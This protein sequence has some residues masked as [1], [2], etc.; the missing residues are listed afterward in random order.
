MRK[1]AL[2]A[3]LFVFVLA[4][5][6][7]RAVNERSR[8]SSDDG[9]EDGERSSVVRA[10]V[11]VTGIPG[12][13]AIAQVG[14]FHK[15]GPFIERPALAGAAH[16]VLDR[17]RLLVA[18]TSNFGA[19]PALSQPEG[20]V[21][22]IDVSG[23]LVAVPPYFATAGTQA[24]AFGDAVILY[25][26]QSAPYQNNV[27][28]GNAATRDLTAVSLP[29]GISL[30]NGFGRPWFAN[31]PNGSGG[32]GSIT[33]IDP[34]GFPLAGAPDPTAGG[35]FSGN[36]TNRSSATTHGIT[37]GAVATAL[38]TKS[39]DGGGKAVFLGALADG[40]VVQIHVQKG[41]DGLAP[42]GSF[43]AIPNISA[44]RAESADREV[45]TRAGMLFNWVPTRVA[46][47]SDPLADRILALDLTDDGTLLKAAAPRYLRSRALR[48]PIDLA[49][50]MPEV[51]ARNFASNTTLAAGSD[52]YVLNR[53]DNS[54][55]RMTQTGDVVAV[56][57]IE[58]DVD[59]FR[60]NGIAVSE[61][62]R[63][64]WITA[65]APNRQGVVLRIPTFGNGEVT[66]SLIGHAAEAGANGAVDQ[67]RNIFAHDVAPD[68][69]LGPLFNGQSCNSC[70]NTPMPGGM[71]IDSDSFVVRVARI[72]A[73]RFDPLT[74]HGGPV[75]R[76]HSIRELGIPCGLPTGV[77]PQ[78]NLTS[79]RSAM[80][81]RGTALID[82]IP[83][84]DILKQASLEA[85]AGI[86]GR[87]NML[88]DG[89]VGRFGWKAQTATLV[90][91]VGQ[92]FRDEIGLTNPLAP[93][94]L[95]RGCGA[96][97]AKPEADAAPPTSLVAFLNTIDPQAPSPAT[98]S[99]DGAI[100][101]QSVGCSACHRPSYPITGSTAP[102]PAKP[103]VMLT[104]FLYSDL[105]LHDMGPGLGD[106]F[107]QS[108]AG[109]N[110][111][112]TAPLWRLDDR[113][114][115]LHDGRA[116]TILDAIITHGGDASSAVTNFNALSAVDRKKLLDFLNGI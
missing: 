60:V 84:A 88:D 48:T 61:D 77:P 54:V 73:G 80:T 46:F 3:A 32:D 33:V 62:A 29:L 106:G 71:G 98:L 35:V 15:G 76:Q 115:F 86:N 34:G 9:E 25:T 6:S 79:R 39:P 22:S 1:A 87:A 66:A 27:K 43:T 89:R 97:S 17:Q 101:F 40:S 75:A 68:E 19:A 56:R 104:A 110:D 2:L 13:G 37:A 113:R 10:E 58:C 28:N 47:V 70:H 91:F 51:A 78:A 44:E 38:T 95:V 31:A 18:S 7:L 16:P 82:D 83:A 53:G 24:H 55:V 72:I 63:T 114:H 93:R 50:A 57:R 41:V 65:T 74:D 5:A 12:A 42:A 59:G 11:V 109:S 36:V 67:G 94:D 23:G 20:S 111:F 49:P 99:S 21:L 26:A 52:F 107:E 102:D 14:A 8:D 105:L 30:N 69:G 45:V 103:T 112:R 81:L 100:L 90:E 108:A 85:A 96:S 92:A 4:F 116:S 64:I